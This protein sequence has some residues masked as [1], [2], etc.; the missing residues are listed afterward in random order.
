MKSAQSARAS[1][2]LPF[3]Y[4][5]VLPEPDGGAAHGDDVGGGGVGL[6]VVGR[7]E[8]VSAAGGEGVDP[9]ADLGFD[10]GLA[11]ERQDVLL[12]DAAVEPPVSTPGCDMRGSLRR[13]RHFVAWLAR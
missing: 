1:V 10:V 4:L 13:Q 2:T 11:A 7:G 6:D 12:V 8:D 3:L 5:C 9:Q